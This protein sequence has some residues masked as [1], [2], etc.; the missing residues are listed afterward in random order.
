VCKLLRDALASPEWQRR[1]KAM[2]LV[3]ALLAAGNVEAR[4][5]FSREAACIRPLLHAAQHSIKDK[6]HKLLEL[7]GDSSVTQAPPEA[8]PHE[9]PTP[10]APTPLREQKL[11]VLPQATPLVDLLEQAPPSLE[12]ELRDEAPLVCRSNFSF[13]NHAI[14]TQPITTAPAP[15]A[16]L[17]TEDA[18]PIPLQ[19]PPSPPPKSA[20]SFIEQT[21]PP[22]NP[23]PSAELH[24]TEQRQPPADTVPFAPLHRMLNDAAASPRAPPSETHNA[25]PILPSTAPPPAATSRGAPPP[26]KLLSDEDV[27]FAQSS[28]L[29]ELA[30]RDLGVGAAVLSQARTRARSLLQAEAEALAR[31]QHEA[32]AQREAQ[33]RRAVNGGGQGEPKIGSG[34][35]DLFL[36]QQMQSALL[37]HA[38][39]AETGFLSPQF[40]IH[41]KS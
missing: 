15:A 35:P 40:A 24:R 26:S 10:E 20:F 18:A 3:E 21:Q 38:A 8:P 4:A 33:A 17:S 14:P 32:Q 34:P 13:M 5:F 31:A 41:A 9:T 30:A 23:M 19:S 12:P 28:P 39:R 16:Y 29:S 25:A 2:S 27:F 7:L 22:T 37:H 6:A 1:L 11:P 36:M